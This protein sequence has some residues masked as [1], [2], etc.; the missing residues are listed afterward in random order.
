MPR[1][2]PGDGL[3]RESPGHP[4]RPDLISVKSQID[5]TEYPR[6]RRDISMGQNPVL[7][8]LVFLENGK[9]NH[10]KNKDFLSL[11]NP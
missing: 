2:C 1:K 10:Q 7:P 11:P 3:G 5:W 4:G 8:F 9:E 6:D